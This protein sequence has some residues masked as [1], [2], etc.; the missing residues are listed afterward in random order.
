MEDLETM[1]L[2]SI[3]LVL[4][5]IMTWMEAKAMTQSLE[6]TEQTISQEDKATMYLTEAMETTKSMV[7]KVMTSSRVVPPM[8]GQ[9][10]IK[11][12]FE[13]ALDKT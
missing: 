2:L 6:E 12:C 8:E 5:G 3:P 10:F 4:T 9:Q 7:A 1:T 13:V 11:K